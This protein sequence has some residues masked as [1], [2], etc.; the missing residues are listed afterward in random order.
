MKQAYNFFVLA[1][2]LIPAYLTAA[3][4]VYIDSPELQSQFI[5]DATTQYQGTLAA[6]PFFK[7]TYTLNLTSKNE[8]VSPPA[9]P[10][11]ITL[12]TLADKLVSISTNSGVDFW[13][14]GMDYER[15]NDAVI[16]GNLLS[17]CSDPKYF[18]VVAIDSTTCNIVAGSISNWI[19]QQTSGV[20]VVPD[21]IK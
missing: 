19:V 4:N 17:H 2:L 20:V 15:H 5:Q 12:D 7:N 11:L 3:V 21:V 9:I 8:L 18:N 16:A 10:I 6:S 14:F 13:A 1:L